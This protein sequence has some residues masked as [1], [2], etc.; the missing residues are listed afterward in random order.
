MRTWSFKRKQ[1]KLATVQEQKPE[2]YFKL[3]LLGDCSTGKTSFANTFS[4]NA[5]SLVKKPPVG[6]V[7]TVEY[8]DRV[9]EVQDKQILARL[10]DTAG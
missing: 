9:L 6:S 8:V 5:C 4:C 10:Y 7:K 2:H 3:V 1:K